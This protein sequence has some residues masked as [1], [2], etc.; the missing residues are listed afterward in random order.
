MPRIL[1]TGN[2]TY[3]IAEALAPHLPNV[4]WLSRAT[5]WDLLQVDQLNRVAGYSLEFDVFLNISKLD[6]FHQILLAQRMACTWIKHAKAGQ[7]I[8][9]GSTADES[10]GQKGPYPAEKA[11]L[12]QYTRQMHNQW[13]RGVHKIR[14]S[15]L[16]VGHVSTPT[17]PMFNDLSVKK[18]TPEEA[19]QAILYL[20]SQPSHI[21]VE[22]L[23]LEATCV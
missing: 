8:N 2:P 17:N 21:N 10:R 5:G 6:V 1:A 7:I 19:A 23:R 4:V 13:L 18:M 11:A 9:V 12:K 16:A 15:Y 20:L 14:M 22:E 3:G